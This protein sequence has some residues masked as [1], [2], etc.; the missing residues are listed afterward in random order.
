MMRA[1]CVKTSIRLALSRTVSVAQPSIGLASTTLGKAH[2]AVA[3]NV[4]SMIM[5][6]TKAQQ[7]PVGGQ[8]R[9]MFSFNA[10]GSQDVSGFVSREVSSGAAIYS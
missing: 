2:S 6:P 5:D 7:P 9:R 8:Q 3:G 1:T 10:A 4:G